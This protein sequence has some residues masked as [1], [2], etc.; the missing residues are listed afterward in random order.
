M[1]RM[2]VTLDEARVH[3]RRDEDDVGADLDLQAKIM[4][5]SEAV[6]SYIKASADTFLDTAGQVLVDSA[7]TPIGV[8]DVVRSATLIMVGYLD[9]VRDDDPDK[10]FRPGFLPTP[11]MA[12][13]YPLRTPT[14]A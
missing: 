10:A 13:L 12:L 1:S 6:L 5:A 3:L 14:V 7:G 9:R 11:V 4:G 2:L 8:P